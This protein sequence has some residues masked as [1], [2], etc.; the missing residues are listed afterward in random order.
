MRNPKQFPDGVH[1]YARELVRI[2]LKW[3]WSGQYVGVKSRISEQAGDRVI[4]RDMRDIL[5]NE[6]VQENALV[7]HKPTSTYRISRNLGSV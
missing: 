2:T 5:V 6:S 1:S 3:T 7:I 4:S